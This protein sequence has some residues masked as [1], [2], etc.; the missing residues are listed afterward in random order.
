MSALRAAG[1]DVVAHVRPDS[2]SLQDWRTRFE[3]LGARV[4]ATPWE[5]EAM[6][7][8]L[9]SVQPQ[10]VFALLGTTRSRTRRVRRQEGKV[11]NFATVDVGLTMM[12]YD[13]ASLCGSRPRFVYLSSIGVTRDT[14]NEYLAA[15]AMVEGRLEQGDL[16]Y[17][18]ARPSFI[19]G[20][21][22]EESRPLERMGAS[23]FDFLLRVAALLGARRLRE[24]YRSTTSTIL[25]GALVRLAL[26]DK[27]T[28]RV[29]QSE[30]LR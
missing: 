18:I 28:S 12:V 19:T 17:V 6:R 15:R 10:L 27:A 9:L 30:E 2:A 23:L 13:A 21:D 8:T 29:Y 4:D 25:A 5:T 20:S 16:P 3:A 14:R 24:R 11:E 1:V 22:R 26:N 7:K